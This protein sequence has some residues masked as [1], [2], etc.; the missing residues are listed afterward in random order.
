MA[1]QP[2]SGGDEPDAGAGRL[3]AAIAGS[4]ARAELDALVLLISNFPD[5]QAARA[6]CSRLLDERLIACANIQ[7]P[8]RSLF[9]WDGQP[10]DESEVPV[11]I[12]T[13]PE[14]A[15]AACARLAQLH[16]Y[17]VPE[18]LVLDARAPIAYA[19]WVGAETTQD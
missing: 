3:E 10:Q 9:C 2:A 8:C 14:L 11:W 5:E 19:A 1:D 15:S 7:A 6:A 17:S 16:P 4:A 12:K 18:I 13:R